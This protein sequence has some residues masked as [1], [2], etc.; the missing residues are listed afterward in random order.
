MYKPWNEPDYTG[1]KFP[2]NGA[3][4]KKNVKHQKRKICNKHVKKLVR[5]IGPFRNICIAVYENGDFMDGN[6]GFIKKRGA[7]FILIRFRT[8]ISNSK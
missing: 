4:A 5:F 6:R 7:N 8:L 1:T 2:T 3:S